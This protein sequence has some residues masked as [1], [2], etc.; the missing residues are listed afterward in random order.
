[1]IARFISAAALVAAPLTACTVERAPAA[2]PPPATPA[3]APPAGTVA[4]IT[5]PCPPVGFWRA[6]GPA[7]AEEIKV[8]GSTAKPGTYDV[9]YKGAALPAGAGT[10]D[11]NKFTV[12][13]GQSTGGLYN[14][15]MNAG[16]T[17]MSCGFTGQTPTLF[18]KTP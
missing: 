8:A 15:T 17:S 5:N 13:V 12:D 4:T 18:N 11:G 14:C 9:S 2:A 1:M 7:G 6:A 3:A 10:Q 16:C